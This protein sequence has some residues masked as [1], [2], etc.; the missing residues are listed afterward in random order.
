MLIL[1]AIF[2]LPL[3]TPHANSPVFL[4]TYL[5]RLDARTPHPQL[6]LDKLHLKRP[7]QAAPRITAPQPLRLSPPHPAS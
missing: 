3:R 7:K 4:A 1:R 5:E 6:L 2:R